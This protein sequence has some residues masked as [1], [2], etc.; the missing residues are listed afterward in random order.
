[1]GSQ[2]FYPVKF[3]GYFRTR[4][5]DDGLRQ[6]YVAVNYRAWRQAGGR[7]SQA[8]SVPAAC[9]SARKAVLQSGV[10]NSKKRQTGKCPSGVQ[11]V[12]QRWRSSGSC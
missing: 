6:H 7:C 10:E 12:Q 11:Q 9:R 3:T 4:V 8:R 2:I 5:G 1:M